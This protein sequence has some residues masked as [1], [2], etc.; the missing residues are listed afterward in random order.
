MQAL[1]HPERATKDLMTI[2]QAMDRAMD[3][4]G[5]RHAAF[6]RT[7][8]QRVMGASGVDIIDDATGDLYFAMAQAQPQNAIWFVDEETA[9]IMAETDPPLDVLTDAPLR[10]PFRGL[11]LALPPIFT[12]RKDTSFGDVKIEGVYLAEDQAMR[13]WT[14]GREKEVTP[15]VLGVAVSQPTGDKND[16]IELLRS[17]R[18]LPG[19]DVL[20]YS[21]YLEDPYAGPIVR[22]VVTF[23][24]AL[25]TGD[26]TTTIIRPTGPKSPGKIKIAERRG[27]R[28]RPYTLVRLGE[29]A[30]VRFQA[31]RLE[32]DEH[33]TVATHYVKRHWRTY[34]VKDPKSEPAFG[35]KPGTHG[36]LFR[37][38]KWIDAF[39]RGV[40][41]PKDRKYRVTGSP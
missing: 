18:L 14:D 31:D 29:E 9:R 21:K 16:P 41:E 38:A 4:A 11:Y 15:V 28:V 35:T 25:V 39:K 32:P 6:S 33:K 24:M 26:L 2:I 19:S 36:T 40:G 20:Y 37:V 1:T 3:L 23:L 34:W 22:L 10:L 12:I 5:I 13:L 8:L 7:G 27:Q 17:F 30:R